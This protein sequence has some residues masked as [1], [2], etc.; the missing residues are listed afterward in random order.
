MRRGEA[1]K[2][3]LIDIITNALGDKVV[4]FQDKKLYVNIPD[5]PV[6]ENVQFAIS[7]TM[8]KTE[9]VATTEQGKP[10]SIQSTQISEEDQKKV[11][12]LLTKLGIDEQF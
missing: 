9:V 1:A 4:T 7:F 3:D 11:Q 8:P 12:E 10:R 5:G 2:K 6:G